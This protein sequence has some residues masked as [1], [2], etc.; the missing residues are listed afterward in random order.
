M[1]EIKPTSA[2]TLKILETAQKITE[3]SLNSAMV[4]Q[5]ISEKESV[6]LLSQI[7]VEEEDE[8]VPEDDIKTTTSKAAEIEE[9]QDDSSTT[10]T[11]SIK[12]SSERSEL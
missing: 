3:Q 5:Q 11:S 2:T 4:T 10:M 7:T 1:L 12:D 9:D 6:N 8:P